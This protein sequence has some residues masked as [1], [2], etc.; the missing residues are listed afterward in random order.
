MSQF[1]RPL[2]PKQPYPTSYY[3]PANERQRWEPSTAPTLPP[4][5]QAGWPTSTSQ[6]F[7]SSSSYPYHSSHSSREAH[8]YRQSHSFSP[9]NCSPEFHSVDRQSNNPYPSPT[10]S[11]P[12]LNGEQQ[13]AGPSIGSSRDRQQQ[14]TQYNEPRR[15]PALRHEPY[16]RLDAREEQETQRE[17]VSLPG[18]IS[19]LSHLV[20][21]TKF[22]RSP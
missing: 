13:L 7:G 17:R 16:R 1:N 12:Q 22:Y 9:I 11:S 3:Q 14:L 15:S 10:F 19:F 2:A 21:L 5:G 8:E 4:F 20:I 6:T 18:I